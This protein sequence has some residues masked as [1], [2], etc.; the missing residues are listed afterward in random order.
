MG[1]TE[2]FLSMLGDGAALVATIARARM[3]RPST[4]TVSEWADEYRRL[5]SKNA[6]EAGKWRTSR[7]P[8][9]R[10]P[11]D[12]LSAGS[13]ANVVVIM[14]GTQI[15]KTEAG[16]NWIGYDI[17][18]APG[19]I[20]I[21]QPTSSVAK[22]WSRQRLAPMIDEMPVLHELVAEN[23]SRDSS[24]S[25]TMKD[26]AGGVLVVAGAN[27]A[28]DLRSM[29]VRDL[30]LDEVDA[31]PL[32]VDGEGDPVE[33]A[34]RRTDNFAR[35][36][37]LITST[38]TTKGFSRVEDAYLAGSRGL[39]HV[40]CPHCQVKAPILWRN[41]RWR[42]GD[43]ETA[44]L[45]CEACGAEIEERFKT[46]MLEGGEW[47]HE[48][49]EQLQRTFRLPSM[50][51]PLGW[52]SWV[53]LV[54]EWLAAKVKS[55]AGDVTLLKVFVNTR[56]AETWEEQGDKVAPHELAKRAEAYPLRT[57]PVGVLA[58][59][60]AVDVQGDRLEVL[61][62][63]WGRGEESWR[64][65][66]VVLHGDPARDDVWQQLDEL[67][68]TPIAH[69]SGATM[70]IEAVA[71]DSGGHHTHE[72]YH[73][74]RARQHRHIF[75][76]KGQSQS[77]KPIL[78]KPTWQDVNFRGDRVKKGVKLWPLGSDTAKSLVYGRLRNETVG[79]GYMHFSED[80][81]PDYYEQV[82]AERLVTRYHRGH[83]KLEWVKPNGRRNEALDL[84]VMNCAAAIYL[85]VSRWRDPDW[86]RREL[87][88]QPKVRD[89][90]QAS[91]DT[92]PESGTL[93]GGE[94]ASPP[95]AAAVQTSARHARPFPRAGGFVGRWQ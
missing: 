19:P 5:S 38:P 95:A 77:G 27:S 30:F 71:I 36:K 10:E 41:I 8:Y 20:M 64:V 3:A 23:R 72:V 17:H 14:A 53:Q 76:V 87:R 78:G 94:N 34:K 66:H 93:A 43:P 50:Y 24:N 85:G 52:T 79:T 49:P 40:P 35:R 4:L 28:A 47:V 68:R 2:A 88:V 32:D 89:L 25:S 44:H 16:N 54:R 21:V 29:P 69:A 90:F 63:G 31:Y 65:D 61:I 83:A 67:L 82:T 60:G 86:T 74:C 59:T 18:Q 1:A 26:F 73:F 37:V 92:P 6:N 84:E 9:L 62:V 57:A 42:D 51:S 7:T 81:Q 11:M 33:L 45:V 22:R 39:Y 55:D 46:Q 13:E 80:L 58:L 70:P 56:L 48:F 12:C 75:A 15:G 91:T